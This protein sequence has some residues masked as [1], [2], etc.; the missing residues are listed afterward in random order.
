MFK[1]TWCCSRGSDATGSKVVASK[2]CRERLE[3]TAGWVPGLRLVRWRGPI[4]LAHRSK[5]TQLHRTSAQNA[6]DGLLYYLIHLTVGLVL[7]TSRGSECVLPPS[8]CPQSLGWVG[9]AGSQSSWECFGE[10]KPFSE[11]NFSV[12]ALE[13]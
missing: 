12:T 13:R 1:S 3:I 10:G 4:A 9:S 8:G 11:E 7:G 5:C 6:Q 2:R